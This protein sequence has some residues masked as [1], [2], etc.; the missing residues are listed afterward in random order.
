ML[1]A[2]AMNKSKTELRS[3][4]LLYRLTLIVISMHSSL[5]LSVS[6]LLAFVFQAA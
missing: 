1:G 2:G 4:G 3:L 5:A 6:T